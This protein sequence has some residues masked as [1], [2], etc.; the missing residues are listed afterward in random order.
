MMFK[1]VEIAGPRPSRAGSA[2]P[3]TQRQQTHADRTPRRTAFAGFHPNAEAIP[4]ALVR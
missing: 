1:P 3:L 2:R 4:A